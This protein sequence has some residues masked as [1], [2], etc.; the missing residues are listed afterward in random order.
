MMLSLQ[1]GV[2]LPRCQLSLR[3][4]SCTK[5]SQQVAAPWPPEPSSAAC[6]SAPSPWRCHTL[7]CCSLS[8]PSG[9]ITLQRFDRAAFLNLSMGCCPKAHRHAQALR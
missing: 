6:A 1:M 5:P 3:C 8:Q 2:P 9:S 4:A 7:L